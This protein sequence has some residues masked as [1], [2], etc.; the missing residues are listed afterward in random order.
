MC[1]PHFWETEADWRAAGAVWW[2]RAALELRRAWK[3]V[4]RIPL[5]G[6]SCSSSCSSGSCGAAA[7]KLR[8]GTQIKETLEKGARRKTARVAMEVTTRQSDNAAGE[9]PPA[10]VRRGTDGPSTSSD[11]KHYTR[12]GSKPR[13]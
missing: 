11:P 8:Q 12:R 10:T 4:A 2:R 13:V 9:A 6:N 3:G 1:A 7:E 5:W